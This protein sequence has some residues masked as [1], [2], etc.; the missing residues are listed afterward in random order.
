MTPWAEVDLLRWKQLRE[1][2]G[3]KIENYN[4]EVK[5]HPVLSGF[6]LI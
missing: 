3:I 4:I 1:E 2:A 5:P 6:L